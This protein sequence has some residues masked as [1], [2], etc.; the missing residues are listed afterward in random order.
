MVARWYIPLFS[1]QKSQFWYKFEGL[2]IYNV[3]IFY[4]NWDYFTTIWY[5]LCPF[6]KFCCH[7]VYFS[8]SGMMNQEISGN[9][10]RKPPAEVESMG[11]N[12][13]NYFLL[14]AYNVHKSIA[15]VVIFSTLT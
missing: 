8:G 9:P 12:S 3:G 15:G 7:L 1:N 6:G 4:S 13:F 14:H 5:I 11:S 10:G 2:G